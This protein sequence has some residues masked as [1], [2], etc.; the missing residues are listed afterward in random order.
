MRHM[1]YTYTGAC[2]RL[3]HWPIKA[4][5]LAC[6]LC[7]CGAA[8]PSDAF[9]SNVLPAATEASTCRSQAHGNRTVCGLSPYSSGV[10]T[11]DE[12]K[13]SLPSH[14]RLEDGGSLPSVVLVLRMQVGDSPLRWFQRMLFLNMTTDVERLNISYWHD[15]GCN[16]RPGP[17]SLLV[18]RGQ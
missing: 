11:R 7:A 8:T 5:T 1:A 18:L 15:K 12:A 6:L 10:G 14:G 4:T 2:L 17:S 9:R 16:W 3:P 13:L